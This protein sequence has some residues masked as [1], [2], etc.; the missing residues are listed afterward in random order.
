MKMPKSPSEVLALIKR[1]KERLG[2]DPRAR[3][4]AE[5]APVAQLG[6]ER[7]RAKQRA[8]DE[9]MVRYRAHEINADDLRRGM[10]EVADRFGVVGLPPRAPSERHKGGPT[11]R[12]AEF[13]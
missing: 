6:E 4:T 2:V 8:L 3:T 12:R 5:P 9:L 10:A 7:A 1:D 11:H 13:R